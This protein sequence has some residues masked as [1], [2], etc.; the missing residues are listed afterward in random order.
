MSIKPIANPIKKK[1]KKKQTSIAYTSTTL[2]QTHSV[3]RRSCPEGHSDAALSRLIVRALY[4]GKILQ[5]SI[6]LTPS[7]A[8]RAPKVTPTPH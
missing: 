6:K 3:E 7:N 1:K 4:Q 8:D 5:R 2:N